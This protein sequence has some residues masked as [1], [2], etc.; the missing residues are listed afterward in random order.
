MGTEEVKQHVRSASDRILRQGAS[1]VHRLPKKISRPLSTSGRRSASLAV[2]RSRQPSDNE[3][4]STQDTALHLAASH[5]QGRLSS[6]PR[7]HPLRA[8]LLLA[9]AFETTCIKIIRRNTKRNSTKRTFRRTSSLFELKSDFWMKNSSRKHPWPA[10]IRPVLA[11]PRQCDLWQHETSMRNSG[12]RF[13]KGLYQH[14]GW[15]GN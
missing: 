2:T 7:A 11:S 14:T 4:E 9:R 12:G 1:A 10:K 8:K 5:A 3:L 6:R 15:T 13:P